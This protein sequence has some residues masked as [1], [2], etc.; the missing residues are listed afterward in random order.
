MFTNISNNINS[1]KITLNDIIEPTSADMENVNKIIL[2]LAQSQTELI[3]KIT[4]YL[5]KAGGKR[6][7]PMLTIACALLFGNCKNEEH[8]K[9]AAAV[10]LMH[11]ATLLHDDV[12]DESDMRRGKASVRKMWGNQASILVGDFLLGKAFTLMVQAGSMPALNVLSNAA[13]VIAEGEVMQLMAAKSLDTSIDDY[14]KIINS[15]TAELFAAST[16]VGAI[17]T[18]ASNKNI[19]ALKLYGQKIGIIFQLV[20]DILDYKGESA[21]LGKNIGDD[22]RE[23]KITLPVL[24]CIENCT[25]E[26]KEFWKQSLCEGQHSEENFTK[27]LALLNKYDSLNKALDISKKYSIEAK[28]A[29]NSI[30]GNIDNKIYAALLEVI[31]FC[32]KRVN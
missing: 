2:S 18:K 19:E 6:I 11:T 12:V 32:I 27:A 15:K 30:E 7:R 4:N 14:F 26:E 31:N 17:I 16:S 21:N 10:E 22:F 23:G 3:P 25:I 9:L 13:S 5:S 8:V 28:E 20:D 24:L 1:S 29:L